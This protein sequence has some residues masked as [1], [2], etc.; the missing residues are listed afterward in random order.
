MELVVIRTFINYFLANI[1]LT[2]LQ[3]SGIECYLKDEF[4]VTLDPAL[5]NAVGG[6]KLVVKKRDEEVAL[7]LLK[8]FDEEY[9]RAT[10]CP[11]CGKHDLSYIEKPNT[12]TYLSV[13]FSLLFSTYAAAPNYV[14]HCDNC[15]Y[16]SKTLPDSYN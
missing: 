16:E 8:Q 4:I 10:A 11:K 13:I 14:Y 7:Q 5:S 12:T 6:I 3:N 15:G 1:I 2:R 9:L